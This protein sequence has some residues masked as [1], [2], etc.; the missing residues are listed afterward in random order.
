V[1]CRVQEEQW[2]NRAAAAEINEMAKC[3]NGHEMSAANDSFQDSASEQSKSQ[4]IRGN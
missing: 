4:P 3:G 1:K 2:Q